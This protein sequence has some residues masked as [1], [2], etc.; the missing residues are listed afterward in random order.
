MS[1]ETKEPTSR[2]R[3]LTGAIGGAGALALGGLA[4]PAG[5][6]A[7]AGDNLKLGQNNDSGTSQTTLNNAGLGAAFTLKTTN[8]SSNATGI[9]GWTSNSGANSTRGVYGRADGN[10]SF[11]V[12]GKQNGAAPGSGAA[13][14]GE[15]NENN[16]VAGVTTTNAS[17]GVFGDNT[18]VGGIGVYGQNQTTDEVNVSVG[19]WGEAQGG[20]VFILFLLFPSAGVHGSHTRTSGTT[21]AAGVWGE[22]FDP[23]ADGVYAINW[24]DT[25]GATGLFA[26]TL[27]TDDNYAGYF[28]GNVFSTGS[29]STATAL[30]VMDHPLDP[31]NAVLQHAGVVSSER[32]TVYSG[33]A[34]IGANGEATVELPD[35]FDAVNSDLRYQLTAVGKQ[36]QAWIKS[37]VKGN[38]FVIGSDTA[39]ATISWQVSGVRADAY[40]KAKPFK[41][42][43]KKTGAAKGKYL[44]PTAHGEAA[45]AGVDYVRSGR[46][47]IDKHGKA[48]VLQSRS[49]AKNGKLKG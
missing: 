10:N 27:A 23:D 43:E 41:A 33:N 44:H 15:G 26:T 25:A 19:V 46:A 2:R 49:D 18:A 3:L 29:F 30:T 6:L 34:K 32:L 7:A 28:S 8:V 42:V 47:A 14:Y 1:D 9:F 5:A 39:G 40:A 20:G 13:V 22:T 12:Y 37:G 4:A 11:G 38:K 24:D 31:T 36:A 16:G 17:Y 35:W 21:I 45:S 48:A